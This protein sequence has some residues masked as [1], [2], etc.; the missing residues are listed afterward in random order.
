MKWVVLMEKRKLPHLVF[1]PG[2]EELRFR[3]KNAYYKWQDGF[4]DVMAAEEEVKVKQKELAQIIDKDPFWPEMFTIWAKKKLDVAPEYAKSIS[5]I[6]YSKLDNRQLLSHLKALHVGMAEAAKTIIYLAIDTLLQ[7]DLEEY[8]IGRIKDKK[9]L[10]EVIESLTS[11]VE[12]SANVE[13][14]LE[15]LKIGELYRVKRTVTPDIKKKLEEHIDNYGWV[16]MDSG[17]GEALTMMVLVQELEKIARERPEMKAAEMRKETVEVVRR[18]GN[19]FEK[20]KLPRNIQTVANYLSQSTYIRTYRR[21]STSRTAWYSQGLYEEIGKRLGLTWDELVYLTQE[22]VYE[23][24][25]AKIGTKRLKKY[26]AENKKFSCAYLD[27]SGEIHFL[28]GNRAEQFAL[29][30]TTD[31]E[32]VGGDILHGRPI[33]LGKATGR[34]KIVTDS[35]DLD[36]VEKG[37]ILVAVQTPPD[38]IRALKKVAGAVVDEGGVTSHASI[39]CRECKVPAIIGTKVA[40][41][42]YKDG[43]LLVLDSTVGVV[44]RIKG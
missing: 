25:G 28:V 31:E 36:K 37:D 21:Y 41:K 38:Y 30:Q 39:L 6:D 8:L 10:A 40:T 33:Y 29:K 23:A 17:H 19:Y 24:L 32:T 13:E 12:V 4:V 42:T 2:L 34:A 35:K 16:A 5:K 1:L 44:Q 7:N 27:D 15:F 43:D 20:Y 11:P 3:Y 18:R 9:N 14:Q 22:Q 26:S